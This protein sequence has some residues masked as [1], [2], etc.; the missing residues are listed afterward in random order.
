MRPEKV[1]LTLGPAPAGRVGAPGRVTDVAYLGMITR[2]VVELDSGRVV[3]AVRQNRSGAAADALAPG[4]EVTATWDLADAF[5][6]ST[7]T[8]R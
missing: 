5:P 7:I 3:T 8:R 1:E 6:L 4:A 2:Y